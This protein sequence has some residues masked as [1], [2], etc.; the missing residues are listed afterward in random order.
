MAGIQLIQFFPFHFE[1][2]NFLSFR[3]GKF[4]QLMAQFDFRIREK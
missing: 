4:G 1:F 2:L 3:I